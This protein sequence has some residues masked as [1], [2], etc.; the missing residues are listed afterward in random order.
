[1]TEAQCTVEETVAWLKTC[2][3]PGAE[4]T[5]DS[6]AVKPG[7]VFVALKGA[8]A[9]GLAW[10]EKAAA[11]GAAAVLYEP[12]EAAPSLSVPVPSLSVP[13]LRRRLGFIASAFYGEPSFEMVGIGITGTN[14]K[15]SISHWVSALL[16]CLGQPCA[17]IGTIGTFFKG[18]RFPA[19]ALTTPDAASTQTLFKAL[20][21][22]G[23]EAFAIEASSIG[24]D[25]GRLSG[26]AFKTAVFTNLTR[27]HL[28]YHGTFEAYEAAKARL[29]D[30][31]GLACA[32]INADDACG[33]RFIE[34]TVKRGV[35]TIAYTVS[36]ETAA[37]AQMLAARTIRPTAS[38][39]AFT[40]LWQGKEYDVA[41]R[42]IGRFNVLN[43]LAVVG[44]AL[45]L[46]CEA[47]E[48]FATLS[49]LDPPAGR[50]QRV[51][52]DEG[53]LCVVD[54]AHTPDALEKVLTAL[55][56]TAEHRGGKLRVVFGAGGDRDHG[57]RPLMGET[58][59]RL[60]D[61]V[62]VTS[63]NPR[64]EDPQSIIDMITAGCKAARTLM[65]EPDRR[66][67]IEATVAE[68]SPCDVVLVAGKGHEDYQEILGVKHHF[69]DVEVVRA[70]L[71]ARSEKVRI[72]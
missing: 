63:D 15:T 48:V 62:T 53:P 69:S 32:V 7:D 8:K 26:T 28:D 46:G 42:A 49:E 52:S 5:L 9:D 40:A 47:A 44:T 61:A 10:A 31:P 36:D 22:A 38:G 21:T 23:A 37:G 60:A 50:L 17:A 34:R 1:M 55:R 13:E 59:S 68:A 27:D 67:A 14:G 56:E 20:K 65:T 33:R 51:A 11:A 72:G 66:R 57:K 3:K 45:S 30:W 64:S 43:L 12:R 24:L 58:A 4:I 70:A 16:T 39:T 41:V 6:R 35:R 2:T 71:V 54:Y 19:P 25:Q 18:S 29:F